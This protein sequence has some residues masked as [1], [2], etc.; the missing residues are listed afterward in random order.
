[1]LLDAAVLLEAKWNDICDCVA[2][3][4]VPVELR[5]QRVLES[6]K[7]DAQEFHRR[8]A[9]Q[10]P[11]ADKRR[12][13]DVVIDN[14]RA[15][16]LQ[17]LK[18]DYASLSAVNPRIIQCSVTGFGLDGAYKDYPALDLIIQAISGYLAITGEPGRP[19]APYGQS[20]S[21]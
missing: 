15:G 13:S 10:F 21:Q 5:L 9:S 4:D 12:A 20:I 8:E 6:R 11:I 16:V 14:F 17:R 2:F 1:M 19:P 7:W 18:V 3:I